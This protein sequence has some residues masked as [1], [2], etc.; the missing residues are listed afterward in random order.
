MS[1]LERDLSGN[2]LKILVDAI[3]TAYPTKTQLKMMIVYGFGMDEHLTALMGGDN[4]QEIVFN[5]ITEWAIPHGK[6][7]YLIE[8]AYQQN[9]NNPKLKDFYEFYQ[10]QPQPQPSIFNPVEI[11]VN[12][13]QL[14]TTKEWN[15]LY[16]ILQQIN[17]N[18]LITEICRQTLKNKQN[19]LLGSCLILSKTIDLTNL[20]DILLNKFP[21]R[22]DD[23]P[24]IVEFV[25]RLSYE[26]DPNLASQL[27]LWTKQIAEKLNISLPTYSKSP[28][29]NETYQYFLLITAIPKGKNQFDLESDLLL[30]DSSR[31]NRKYRNSS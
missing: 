20:K 25:E 10:K 21:K 5:F 17:N 11:S 7:E 12:N 31:F 24:T 16:F 26:V 14:I 30:Y 28:L 22:K 2:E 18:Q 8:K 19:D 3:I 13:S 27:N 1:K 4:L 23:I 29:N 15:K 9:L 6:I